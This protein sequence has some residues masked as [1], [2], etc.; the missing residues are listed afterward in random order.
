MNPIA[1]IEKLINERGSAKILQER[2]ALAADQF[3]VLDRENIDLRVKLREAES[4]IESLESRNANLEKELDKLRSKEHRLEDPTRKVLQ[5]LFDA[6]DGVELEHVARRMSLATSEAKFHL[7]CLIEL[8]F[9]GFH[10]GS[11]GFGYTDAYGESHYSGG[12]PETYWIKQK[13]RA[14]IMKTR[15]EQAAPHNP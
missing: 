3:T 13:G 11:V 12:T 8:D 2:L 6:A 5:L 10:E 15:C 9:I 14:Y 1:A 7:G 4:K